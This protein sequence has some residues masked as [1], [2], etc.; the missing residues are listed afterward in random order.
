[1]ILRPGVMHYLIRFMGG[2]GVLAE[3]VVLYVG[4]KV[5]FLVFKNVN[6]Q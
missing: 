4:S 2:I 1:M 5:L 6:R 3:I